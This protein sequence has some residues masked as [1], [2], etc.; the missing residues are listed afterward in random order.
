MTENQEL[1]TEL[2]INDLKIIANVIELATNRGLFKANDLTVVGKV[3][4]KIAAVLNTI[5]NEV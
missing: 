5:K 3:F 2:T 4:D 1:Q